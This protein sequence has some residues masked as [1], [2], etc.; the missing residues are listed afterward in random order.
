[1]ISAS[2]DSATYYGKVLTFIQET[3]DY[4]KNYHKEITK[5]LI[6]GGSLGGEIAE[7][8][9]ADPKSQQIISPF[10]P[11]NVSIV[12]F[13]SPGIPSDKYNS[14][15]PLMNRVLGIYNSSDPI[16]NHSGVFAV[17]SAFKH[18]GPQKELYTPTTSFPTSHVQDTYEAE[19]QALTSSAL[20]Q[21]ADAKTILVFDDGSAGTL[22]VNNA[23]LGIPKGPH[24]IVALK[25][26]DTIIGSPGDSILAWSGTHFI[27]GSGAGPNRYEIITGNDEIS[28]FQ[29]SKD[30][31][32]WHSNVPADGKFILQPYVRTVL[33]YT[34]ANQQKGTITLDGVNLGPVASQTPSLHWEGTV[35]T[36]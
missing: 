27:T 3:I 6:T 34:Q 33:T 31:L 11:A 17:F 4:V 28:N 30:Q 23:S 36:A 21:S 24:F 29:V 15:S 14:N 25:G 18:V 26:T 8:F 2:L 22:E 12:T 1:M 7:L 19:I 16:Y 35:T 13:S 9:A 10:A 5:L 20:F 32:T